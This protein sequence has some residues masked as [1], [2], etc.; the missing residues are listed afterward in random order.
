MRMTLNLYCFWEI[1]HQFFGVGCA[2]QQ[3]RNEQGPGW[4]EPRHRLSS[5]DSAHTA[6]HQQCYRGAGH[7]AAKWPILEAEQ[8]TDLSKANPGWQ[9]KTSLESEHKPWLD[10][11]GDSD[12]PSPL[13]ATLGAGISPVF[14]WHRQT[15]TWLSERKLS[16]SP[17]EACQWALSACTLLVAHVG[18]SYPQLLT[19]NWKMERRGFMLFSFSFMVY[20]H[21]AHEGHFGPWQV[22]NWHILSCSK[23][24]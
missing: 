16:F 19:A 14:P 18:C 22:F 1:T 13:Q 3:S 6:N 12:L 2:L 4:E 11:M 9:Q 8:Q 21:G 20:G 17:A 24:L 10:S 23:G 5:R 7:H 15:V